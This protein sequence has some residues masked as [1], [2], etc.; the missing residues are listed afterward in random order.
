M[1]RVEMTG[2]L[3]RPVELMYTR[4]GTPLASFT[5][6]VDSTPRWD[7]ELKKSV[8]HGNFI[9]VQLWGAAAERMAD[10]DPPKGA[11]LYVLGELDQSEYEK[12]DGTR[13]SKTRVKAWMVH[14]LDRPA[15]ERPEV[16]PVM[17]EEAP[18]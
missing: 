15:D 7:A 8:S 12:K 14:W 16:A 6:V 10:D 1:N 11:N 4:H 13:E 9:S 18:F 17:D 3:V 5:V 2:R